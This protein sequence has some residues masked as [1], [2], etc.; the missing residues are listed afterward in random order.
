MRSQS[1]FV[2]LKDFLERRGD[3]FIYT[4]EGSINS[5]I[6][7]GVEWVCVDVKESGGQGH[8]LNRIWKKDLN[9]WLE[10]YGADM[11]RYNN[12]YKEQF[13]QLGAIERSIGEV[14]VLID[15]DNC[16]WRT[17]FLLGYITQETYIKGLKKKEWKV[18]RNACVGSCVK[19][20]VRVPYVKGKRDLSRRERI[21]APIEYHY[22]RNHIIG[23]IYR[24]FY[25]LFEELGENFY[26]FLTDCVVTNYKN[27]ARVEQFFTKHGYETKSKPVEFLRIVRPTKQVFWYDFTSNDG[28]GKEKYYIYA[29]NQ[30]V[31]G[32][33]NL[34]I[35]ENNERFNEK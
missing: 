16:Y 29:N 22:V 33:S 19:S 25:Q 7:G 3:D 24:L 18:G 20:K 4:S 30:L 28:K 32:T 2:S 35:L 23:H 5:I 27:K 14:N 13:F 31:D 11:P 8:H 17:S 34:S 21:L 15:I 26:M 12:D 9:A 1:A 6:H 10:E